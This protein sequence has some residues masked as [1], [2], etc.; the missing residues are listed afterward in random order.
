VLKVRRNETWVTPKKSS[1]AKKHVLSDGLRGP[2]PGERGV[3][4][5][6]TPKATT[7]ADQGQSGTLKLQLSYLSGEEAPSFSREKAADRR[8]TLLKRKEKKKR[9]LGVPPPT[10]ATPIK[11]PSRSQTGSVTTPKKKEPQKKAEGKHLETGLK[12]SLTG[13]GRLRPTSEPR[14]AVKI[15]LES[16]QRRE[17]TGHHRSKKK[18]DG[19]RSST[20]KKAAKEKTPAWGPSQ[21]PQGTGSTNPGQGATENDAF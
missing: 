9:G 20:R 3:H 21:K 5:T 12:T 4:E 15:D 7:H 6:T 13:K 17:R 2:S 8:R 19:G 1:H 14:R 11:K 10:Q 18:K 16:R